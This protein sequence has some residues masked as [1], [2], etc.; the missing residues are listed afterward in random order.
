MVTDEEIEARVVRGADRL[1]ERV[2]QDWPFAV[3]LRD[4]SMVSCDSCVLGQ[5]EGAY[6]CGL[7]AIDVAPERAADYGFSWWGDVDS[8]AFWRRLGRAWRAEINRRRTSR[9]RRSK[10]VRAD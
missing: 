2:G 3:N 5:V 7:D 9:V 6:G 4:L 10:A 1:D 8:V